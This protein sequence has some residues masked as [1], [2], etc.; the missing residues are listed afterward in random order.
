MSDL[1]I[2]YTY[3]TYSPYTYLYNQNFPNSLTINM[4]MWTLVI[5]EALPHA[6]SLVTKDSVPESTVEAIM[7]YG[8]GLN[9]KKDVTVV[10][11]Y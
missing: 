10:F 4:N 7:A 3:N 1:H 6:I 9:D 5:K 8:E 2:T 11:S